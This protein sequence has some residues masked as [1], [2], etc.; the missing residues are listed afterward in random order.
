M[1]EHA[2]LVTPERRPVGVALV[3][4][5]NPPV[6]A[7]T[8]PLFAELLTVFALEAR[9][10]RPTGWVRRPHRRRVTPN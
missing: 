9:S 5:D 8:T 3:T 1:T 7:L 4:I 2:S 6:N 10:R